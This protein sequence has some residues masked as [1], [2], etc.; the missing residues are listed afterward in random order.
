MKPIVLAALLVTGTWLGSLAGQ[1]L[2]GTYLLPDEAGSWTP[3]PGAHVARPVE[4]PIRVQIRGVGEFMV[5]PAQL[6]T[7]RPDVF[8]PGQFSL[9]DLLVYLAEQGEIELSYHYD[10]LVAT[11]VIDSLNGV[12]GWWYRAHYAGGWFETSAVRMDLYPVKTGTEVR[13][14]RERAG[15]L[16]R[17]FSAYRE[18][19]ERLERNGGRV[20]LPRVTIR[21]PDWTLEFTHVEV[22]PHGVRS[23]MLRPRVVTA[24]D[25][26]LS[27]GEQGNLAGL[28]LTW[29]GRI[30]AAAPVDTYFVEYI[31][32]EGHSA[33]ARG[34]C[35]FV[36]EVGSLEF[37]GF[38]GSHVHIP[39]D[40]RVIVSPE[41]MEWFWI[42]L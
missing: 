29:Y 11:H 16:E 26:L 34:S 37:P 24:L 22:T 38:R 36:Y 10:E 13:F 15:W 8:S 6:T 33:R 32:G 39:S 5:D 19:V 1:Q 25:V 3:P 7:V 35:G 28:G 9:F 2:P 42:C 31:A 12:G 20:I 40:I 18:E 17:L 41:Y 30:G 4:G 27:L 14:F 21:G 23:D